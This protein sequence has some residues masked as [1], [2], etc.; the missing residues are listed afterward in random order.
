MRQRD[1]LR[2]EMVIAYG[3][4]CSHCA[5]ADPAVL[6]LDHIHNDGA[7]ERRQG[8]WGDPF[9]KKLKQ[10]G[11]PKG[12]LQLLCHNCNARKEMRRRRNNLLAKLDG[13]DTA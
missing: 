8:K 5:E 1:Q 10:D 12:R 13:G 3:G 6:V 4:T 11:W 7:E 9:F 2:A